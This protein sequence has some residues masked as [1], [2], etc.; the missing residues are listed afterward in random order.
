VIHALLCTLRLRQRRW[1]VR[2]DA[3]LKTFYDVYV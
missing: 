1:V 3:D 2:W